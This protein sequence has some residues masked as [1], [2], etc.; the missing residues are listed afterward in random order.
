ME[1]NDKTMVQVP[2]EIRTLKQNK[3]EKLIIKTRKYGDQKWVLE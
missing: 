1:E 3:T 2:K